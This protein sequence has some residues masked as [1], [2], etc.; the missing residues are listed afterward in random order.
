MHLDAVALATVFPLSLVT[1]FQ[2][3]G[4]GALATAGI[5][6]NKGDPHTGRHMD[7]LGRHFRHQPFNTGAQTLGQCLGLIGI[8]NRQQDGEILTV[9]PG[10]FGISHLAT[11]PVGNRAENIIGTID[12]H[13]RLVLLKVVQAEIQHRRQLSFA[14]RLGH[15]IIKLVHKPLAGKQ[16]GNLVFLA[17]FLEPFLHFA[18][19][20]AA[21]ANHD[22]GAGLT[23]IG[24]GREGKGRIKL[25]AIGIDA[26]AF[27]FLGLAFILGTTTQ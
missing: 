6:A 7:R 4:K 16:A 3:R 9:Y 21:G 20:H 5:L 23:I 12:T 1:A 11:Q 13:R 24:A 10:Q 17:H 2:C 25:F 22:L 19:V 26:L 18:L 15:R 14:S 8:R 27:Q